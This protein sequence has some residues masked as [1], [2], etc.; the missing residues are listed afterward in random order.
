MTSSANSALISNI[1]LLSS[2]QH[3]KLLRKY[4]AFCVLCTLSK[5]II[6]NVDNFKFFA[7]SDTIKALNLNG[8]LVIL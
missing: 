2:M 5:I 7:S 4:S 8:L 6:T 1:A 3:G